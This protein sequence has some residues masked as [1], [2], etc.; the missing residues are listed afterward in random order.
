[1][2]PVEYR[3][4][5]MCICCEHCGTSNFIMEYYPGNICCEINIPAGVPESKEDK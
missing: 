5:R 2:T 1:M 4:G 3:F